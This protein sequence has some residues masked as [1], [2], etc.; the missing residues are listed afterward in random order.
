MQH[1]PKHKTVVRE[2]KTRWGS[3][4]CTRTERTY[5]QP[6]SFRA[7][8]ASRQPRL[9]QL[10]RRMYLLSRGLQPPSGCLIMA[11]KTEQ[12]KID[13]R[14]GGTHGGDVLVEQEVVRRRRRPTPHTADVVR[15]RRDQPLELPG[16][17]HCPL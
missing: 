4:W 13:W 8:S 9:A 1:G 10:L 14:N 5:R 16:R 6:P 17:L 2:E 3:I 15:A 12:A 7:L 11:P